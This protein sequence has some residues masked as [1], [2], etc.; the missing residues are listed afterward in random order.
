MQTKFI[1]VS[2]FQKTIT[3]LEFGF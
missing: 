1:S 3:N 2:I